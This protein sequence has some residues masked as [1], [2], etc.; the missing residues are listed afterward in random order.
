[1]DV[2][3]EKQAQTE[4]ASQ[5]LDDRVNG[6]E[7]IKRTWPEGKYCIFASGSCAPNFT[8]QHG[9]LKAIAVATAKNPHYL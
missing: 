5:A 7:G 4:K 9:Y 2:L 8:R 3:R 1:M 6:W